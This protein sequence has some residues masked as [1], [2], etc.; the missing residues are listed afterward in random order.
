[1][2]SNKLIPFIPVD[3]VKKPMTKAALCDV[4]L[5]FIFQLQ[6]LALHWRLNAQTS[7]P[8]EG[9]PVGDQLATRRLPQE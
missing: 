1:M 4:N 3:L 7:L 8:R 2:R 6:N 9:K 5:F